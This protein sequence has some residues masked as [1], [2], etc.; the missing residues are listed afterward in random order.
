MLNKL[1]SKQGF[2]LIE[3]LI[4]VAIIG[5][6][7]AIA[8]PQ[9]SAYQKRGYAST[10]RS[11]ARN[12]HTAI[13]A[14]FADNPGAGT[15]ALLGVTVLTYGGTTNVQPLATSPLKAAKVTNGTTLVLLDGA[16]EDDYNITGTHVKLTTGNY[17]INGAGSV[18][19]TLSSGF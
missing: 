4:V 8:I 7:A 14:A 3:L 12:M 2:T 6:L 13:K 9:F 16:T 1:R 17:W 19:D 11:D 18:T 15:L 5:I 10:V